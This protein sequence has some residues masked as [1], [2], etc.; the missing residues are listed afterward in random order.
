MGTRWYLHSINDNAHTNEIL[1][2]IIG[3]QFR[4]AE[5]RDT[6]CSDSVRRN[7]Y[8][9]PS[10]YQDVRR[11]VANVSTYNLKLE[12]FQQESDGPIVQ[13][14]LWKQAVRK[15]ARRARTPVRRAS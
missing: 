11:A 5:C 13:Y 6:L 10:G 7:L 3:E 1:S 9:C 8:R 2:S 14:N 15:K 12:I 4:D